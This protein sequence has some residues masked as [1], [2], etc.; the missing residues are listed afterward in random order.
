[1]S[2][3]SSSKFKNLLPS[4]SLS[5]PDLRQAVAYHLGQLLVILEQV[6]QDGIPPSL[7]G[8]P[9]WWEDEDYLYLEFAPLNGPTSE[10]DLNVHNGT[11]FIRVER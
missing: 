5:R 11:A 2:Q 7:E 3:L 10:I 6:R 1:M 9:Q 4:P 8:D